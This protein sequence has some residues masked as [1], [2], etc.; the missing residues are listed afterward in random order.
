MKKKIDGNRG[1][2]NYISAWVEFNSFFRDSPRNIF[3]IAN[4][5]FTDVFSVFYYRVCYYVEY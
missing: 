3:E 5:L 2:E 1:R 4:H